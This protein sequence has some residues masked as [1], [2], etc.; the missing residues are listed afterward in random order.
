V[1][2]SSGAVF[3]SP[4]NSPFIG[5]ANNSKSKKLLP[6]HGFFL[7]LLSGF[8]PHNVIFFDTCTVSVLSLTPSPGNSQPLNYPIAPNGFPNQPLNENLG[9]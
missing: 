2:P 1:F 6:F 4:D 5:A 3:L 9:N 7:H 8:E